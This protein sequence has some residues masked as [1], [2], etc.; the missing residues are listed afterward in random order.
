MI[1]MDQSWIDELKSVPFKSSKYLIR[2]N[3]YI[4]AH[5]RTIFLLKAKAKVT[6]S[7]RKRTM[8][9]MATPKLP[10]EASGFFQNKVKEGMAKTKKDTTEKM[11]GVIENP[12]K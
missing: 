11:E 8:H 3:I 4:E 9:T 10:H 2:S 12:N 1:L 5:G 6:K 7:D